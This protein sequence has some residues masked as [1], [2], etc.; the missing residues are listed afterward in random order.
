MGRSVMTHPDALDTVYRTLDY[1]GF[2]DECGMLTFAGDSG[3]CEECGGELEPDHSG[4]FASHEFEYLVDWVREEFTG[5]FPSMDTCDRRAD[6]YGAMDELRCI[7]ANELCDVYISEFCGMVSISVVPTGEESYDEDTTG[8][9]R[10][11]TAANA[12]PVLEKFRE[13]ARLGTM[14]NGES[15]YKKVAA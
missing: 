1:G 12:V 6:G 14:S 10:Y 8:L 7:V 9:A 13:F 3:E 2:C 4:E 15:V 11:W 5:K